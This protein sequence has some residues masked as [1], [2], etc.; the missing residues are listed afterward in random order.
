MLIRVRVNGEWREADVWPGS[1]LLNVLR[2]ELGPPWLE[3][4][5]RGG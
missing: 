4:R 5:V 1:N 2:E 3:E